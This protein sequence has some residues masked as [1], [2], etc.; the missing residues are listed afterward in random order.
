MVIK[1]VE[2]QEVRLL[3]LKF[4][5][6]QMNNDIK[7]QL[8]DLPVVGMVGS[9]PEHPQE[10]GSGSGSGS[11]THESGLEMGDPGSDRT[12]SV[13]ND[14]DDLDAVL[15]HPEDSPVILASG[16]ENTSDDLD[17]ELTVQEGLQSMA[18]VQVYKPKCLECGHLVT[19]AKTFYTSCHVSA[20]NAM[21]PAQSMR[22]TENI[23]LEKIIAAFREAERHGD[24]A[25]VSRLYAQVAKKPDWV[26]QRVNDELKKARSRSDW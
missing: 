3:N 16:A 20:G 8:Q 4:G 26:Q 11:G 23:P 19:W 5:E 13:G 24:L 12:T 14:N 2:T 17:P 25:R 21:C 1:T 18:V 10:S 7:A 15:G 6:P 22:I 9:H